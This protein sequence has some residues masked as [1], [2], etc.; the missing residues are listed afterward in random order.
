MRVC[1]C[2]WRTRV[3][4]SGGGVTVESAWYYNVSP[5]LKCMQSYSRSAL[6][7]R[8]SKT[9]PLTSVPMWKYKIKVLTHRVN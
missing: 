4:V 2:V 6:P 3:C 9:L 8:R 5:V 1:V 7:R